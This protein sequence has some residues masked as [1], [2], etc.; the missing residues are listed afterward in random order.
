MI[1]FGFI[2]SFICLV[3]FYLALLLKESKD[4]IKESK[5]ILQNSKGSLLKLGKMIEELEG[6]VSIARGTVEEI[7]NGILK[8]I[9]ALSGFVGSMG[10]TLASREEKKRKDPSIEDLLNE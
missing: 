1:I 5:E 6:T 10:A 7:S 8:P 3:L 4:T 9:R 2:S